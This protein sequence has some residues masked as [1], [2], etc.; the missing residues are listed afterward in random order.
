MNISNLFFQK[1]APK[2]KKPVEIVFRVPKI[3]YSEEDEKR[4]AEAK[5]DYDKFM[6]RQEKI[7][8][9][10][11]TKQFDKILEEDQEEDEEEDDEEDEEED[12]EWLKEQHKKNEATM[13]K[14][15]NEI[16]GKTEEGQEEVQEEVQEE[17]VSNVENVIQNKEIKSDDEEDVSDLFHN[18]I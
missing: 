16:L 2:K 9:A 15:A 13:L 1:K 3:T 5:K 12:D 7:R 6:A 8:E 17:A 14:K 4:I 11:K 10:I 18:E